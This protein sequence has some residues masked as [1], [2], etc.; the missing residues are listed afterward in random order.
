MFK[1]SG[2]SGIRKD[3]VCLLLQWFIFYAFCSTSLDRCAYESSYDYI[4]PNLR[5]NGMS[6]LHFEIS[7]HHSYSVVWLHIS[8]A[9]R[10]SSSSTSIIALFFFDYRCLLTW[11]VPLW[12]SLRLLCSIPRFTRVLF[13]EGSLMQFCQ[14]N[15][16]INGLQTDT[17]DTLIVPL[18]GRSWESRF[19]RKATF[20]FS[21]D[22]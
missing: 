3:A 9:E 17:S 1:W 22:E 11:L 14:M 5:E 21:W 8:G 4:M 7:F 6:L 15:E 13:T 20:P 18:F 10:I 12:V 16:Q 19:S 2:D